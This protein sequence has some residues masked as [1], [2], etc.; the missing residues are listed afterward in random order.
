[1]K[2]VCLKIS[3]W[4]FFFKT[5]RWPL[6]FR[7]ILNLRDTPILT[8]WVLL[9][10]FC[11]FLY[12][13]HHRVLWSFIMFTEFSIRAELMTFKGHMMICNFLLSCRR[14]R[15]QQNIILQRWLSKKVL[16]LL[17]RSF[18]HEFSVMTWGIRSSHSGSV[19]ICC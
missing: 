6:N 18:D 15:I 5:D 9:E 16:F 2:D 8:L 7:S 12:Q 19:Y 10:L 11:F 4:E 3:H 13:I 14:G 17:L 1:M